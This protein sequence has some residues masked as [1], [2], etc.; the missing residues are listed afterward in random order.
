MTL[1]AT[2]AAKAAAEKATKATVGAKAHTTSHKMPVVWTLRPRFRPIF[3]AMPRPAEHDVLLANNGLVY[4]SPTCIADKWNQNGL[5]AATTLKRDQV[6]GQ[7]T[8]PRVRSSAVTKEDQHYLMVARSTKTEGKL[9]TIDGRPC[10][11]NP[12]LAGFANYST[13]PN[14][15]FVDDCVFLLSDK[16]TG[17]TNV[18]LITLEEI[19]PGCEIRVNYD[20]DDADTSFRRMLLTMGV[21]PA[22]LD[23]DAYKLV[24][25]EYPTELLR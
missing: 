18:L 21:A 1:P 10:A 14:A 7:Y 22:D 15:M 19:L 24:Q 16:H 4:A 9:H 2:E 17:A 5:F 13:Q 11:D 20:G 3:N 12:N 25:W 23:N 8:G 6:I